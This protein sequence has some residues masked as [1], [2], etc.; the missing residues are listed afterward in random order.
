[1]FWFRFKKNF[2]ANA[3]GV[4]L[5]CC[6]SVVMVWWAV[7][8]FDCWLI[9]FFFF[10]DC[11]ADSN[12]LYYCLSDQDFVMVLLGRYGN[13]FRDNMYT[14]SLPLLDIKKTRPSRT[15]W[16]ISSQMKISETT[17]VSGWLHST[18]WASSFEMQVGRGRVKKYVYLPNF[19]NR[20]G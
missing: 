16:T 1:M 2:Q 20:K 10:F 18:G 15:F 13:L 3:V 12:D 11:M 5:L 17:M 8:P 7:V 9:F 14:I 19:L 4:P 6:F